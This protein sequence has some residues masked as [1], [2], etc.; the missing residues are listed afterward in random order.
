MAITNGYATLAEVKSWIPNIIEG[1]IVQFSDSS[2]NTT[3]L[4][5]TGGATFG[6]IIA[7]NVQISITSATGNYDGL[8][9]IFNVNRGV[10]FDIA[11]AFVNDDVP[12]TF[13]TTT[14]FD[15][16]LE[17]L[18]EAISRQI[19]DN[20]RTRFY[21][22]NET[23]D[24]YPRSAQVVYIDDCV[25]ITEVKID[26]D[27]DGSFS[28][29]LSSTDY[30]PFP[31]NYSADGVPVRKLQ[32]NPSSSKLFPRLV[33]GY[34]SNIPNY[35]EG[36]TVASSYDGYGGIARPISNRAGV[37]IPTVRV[38]GDF[39]Y[40]STTP[41]S[42]K[43]ATKLAVQKFFKR[44]DAPFGVTGGGDFQQTLVDLFNRDTMLRMMLETI[45]KR[46]SLL[47]N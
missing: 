37:L 30:I 13:T 45:P 32:V 19:D 21:T 33:T 46:H 25:S 12:A 16:I 3:V 47:S 27:F 5:N 41:P 39:G 40:S 10:S 22:V 4:T 15:D 31:I 11:T 35:Y 34:S 1:T 8:Y 36:N 38:T 24:Y 7:D 42:V 9:T 44:R 29:T 20:R 14:E 17:N 23:R 6:S 43:A 2:P 26:P 28:E 18:V